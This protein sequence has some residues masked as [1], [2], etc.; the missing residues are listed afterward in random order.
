MRDSIEQ[1][2]VNLRIEE[3]S[4]R[5]ALDFISA[6]VG[7]NCLVALYEAGILEQLL[8]NGSIDKTDIETCNNPICIKSALITLEKCD[9]IEKNL[10]L[11]KITEFGR[12]LSEYIGLITIFFDGYGILVANQAQIIQ[13]KCS[14]LEN[15]V[16]WPVVAKSSIYISEKTVDLVIIRELMNLK[17]SGTICDLGCGCG[18][19]LSKICKTTGNPGLGFESNPST[20]N[21]AQGQLADNITVEVADIINLQGVWK[22]VVCLIQAFVFHDFTPDNNCIDIMNSYLESFPNL[23]CFF[24]IDIMTPSDAKNEL[25]P[26][27]DYVHGLL[28]TPT[29]TYEETINM[30]DQSKYK[31]LKEV[32]IPDLPNTFLWILSPQGRN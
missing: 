32:G 30:F 13:N 12:V 10:D 5:K 26:G 23:K 22:D 8:K 28:G 9:I 16:K 18:I 29:R 14:S 7:C 27:F 6:G 25:F 31:V 11:F 24:Y 3:E 19:M 1:K 20:V 21:E 15:L 4:K 17:L 2:K